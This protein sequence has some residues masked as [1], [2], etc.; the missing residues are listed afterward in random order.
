MAGLSAASG[1]SMPAPAPGQQNSMLTVVETKQQT[2]STGF[3]V[4]GMLPSAFSSLASHLAGM[5]NEFETS[6]SVR[7]RDWIECIRAYHGRYDPQ[8]EQRLQ[9]NPNRSKIFFQLTKTKVITAYA[10]I[11]DIYFSNPLSDFWSIEPTA[12]PDLPVNTRQTYISKAVQEVVA[13]SG[14]PSE[15]PELKPI[16]R[17]RVMELMDSHSREWREEA[18]ESADAMTREIRDIFDES[19]AEEEI[20]ASILECCTIGTGCV[21]GVL[22]NVE[23]QTS[24]QQVTPGVWDIVRTQK[25][26]GTVESVSCFEVYPDPHCSNP[27]K[28]ERMFHRKIMSRTE[29]EA[30]RSQPGF[31]QSEID[32]V[33]MSSP[34]GNH[35]YK[36]WENELNQ[37]SGL[38]T[39][40][41][42]NKYEVLIY[43]GTVP[44]HI[45]RQ[46]GFDVDPLKSQN[47][48]VYTSG[49][50]V[51]G[52][53]TNPSKSGKIPYHFFPYEQTNGRFFGTG[54][55]QSLFDSQKV[56]NSAIRLFIDNTALSSG[57]LV[58][59]NVDLLD[60]SE[61]STAHQIFPWR[62][63]KR[64][65]G[66][67]QSPAVR[68]YQ[69][70]SVAPQVMKLI[71]L[72]RRF[73]D[74]ESNLPSYTHGATTPGLNKTASGMSMLMN[75]SNVA[76][77]AV[78]KNIDTYG[79]KP[80]V[81]SAYDHCMQFSSNELAKSGDLK[82]VVHGSSTLVAKELQSQRLMQFAA[83]TANPMDAQLTKRHGMLR[84]IAKSLDIDPDEA[85]LNDDEY[86]EMKR[87]MASQN[88]P[89][90][91]QP[92]M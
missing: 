32:A 60:P 48:V 24:W 83:M 64:R 30:L 53:R 58:E 17:Q 66:D 46:N 47:I 56:L 14:L 23:E 85:V 57:P 51:L 6:R 90:Q 7:E 69:P 11:I 73:A 81:Q 80:L 18:Q 45:L 33:L 37:L 70:R 8:T 62:V 31:F 49:G 74:E 39:M 61:L 15:A 52:V 76:L 16:I 65:G 21:A 86:D 84:S 26:G 35:V 12:V 2:D 67:D 59:V 36:P 54:V 3:S 1:Y 79:I 44:G 5:F 82:T 68:F 29:M 22:V 92:M 50:Y 10:R 63:F 41:T 28:L 4:S 89:P 75:A 20:K 72:M 77:K 88:Q 38:M 13:L 40:G 19:G 9:Q 55:A 27:R 42:S 43:W 25:A 87:A 34:N 71:D 78:I 91:A